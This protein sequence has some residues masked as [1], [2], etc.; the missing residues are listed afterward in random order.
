[1]KKVAMAAD[2]DDTWVKQCD[3]SQ[4]LSG[5]SQ[6][7]SIQASKSTD[8]PWSPDMVP[9]WKEKASYLVTGLLNRIASIVKGAV[10]GSYWNRHCGNTFAS[11]TIIDIFVASFLT[12][13]AALLS[14]IICE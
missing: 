3:F 11:S 9:F 13:E 5:Y 7:L 10:L 14:S 2:R 1:M 8:Q 6:L 12:K 4:D